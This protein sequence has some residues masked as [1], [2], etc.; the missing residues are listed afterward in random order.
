MQ[1]RRDHVQS[2]QF[3]M[4]RLASALVGG[5]P[6]QGDSPT[7][8]SALGTVLGAG[9]AVLLCGGFAVAG[10]LAPPAS[11]A[12]RKDGAV[13]VEKETGNRYVYL[14]GELRPARN[15]ASA[16]LIAGGPAAPETVP[17][18]V[19]AGTPRGV[20]VGIPDAPDAVPAAAG[21][22]DGA[23]ARCLRTD[24]TGA[25]A[26]GAAGGGAPAG[27]AAGGGGQGAGGGAAGGAVPVGQTLVFG[28]AA[29][30]L[31][32]LPAGRAALVAGPDG[33]RHLLVGDT[34][35]AVPADSALIALGLDDRP[36]VAVPADWL[37][38]VPTGAPLAASAPPGAGAPAGTVAGQSTVTGQLFST[39]PGADAHHYVQRADGLAPVGPTEY[40]LLAAL[41]GAPAPR[42]VTAADLATA[43]LSADRGA[44]NRLP[45][46]T[47]LPA[48]DAGALCLRTGP[49]GTVRLVLAPVLA[50]PV[51]LPPGTGVLATGPVGGPPYL[52][53]EQGARYRVTDGDAL[54]ALGLG[55]ARRV[56]TLPADVLALLPEGPALGRAAARR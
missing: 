30:V 48:P 36:A 45:A 53:T 55:D 39:G 23:W 25:P 28:P 27:S 22:L 7:R 32:G 26:P 10:L 18:E 56:L 4:G 2:Y 9:V 34:K 3:A 5:D 16:L 42:T 35:Y 11:T 24:V 52:V 47:G 12:W 37:A 14:G 41:P 49:G 17:A 13:V 38:A 19:L 1:T 8:R 43:P 6:G 54:R 50:R 21:L 15:Q 33:A 51:V 29:D 31:P 40:A 46:V 44:L 20:P